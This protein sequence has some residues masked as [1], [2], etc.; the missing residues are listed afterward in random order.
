MDNPGILGFGGRLRYF[1]CG[2][3]TCRWEGVLW[4]RQ[5]GVEELGGMGEMGMWTWLMGNA[6][7]S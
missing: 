1:C 3:S 2:C 4:L 7:R 5:R 6:G